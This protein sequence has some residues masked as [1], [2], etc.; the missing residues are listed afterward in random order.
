MEELNS[1][2]TIIK[3]ISEKRWEFRSF[4]EKCGLERGLLMRLQSEYRDLESED[5]RK[6]AN[7]FGWE[8]KEKG[9]SIIDME[10][11]GQEGL[12]IIE[13]SVQEGEMGNLYEEGT[14]EWANLKIEEYLKNKR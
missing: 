5:I 9:Y 2:M 7:M 4:E 1:L 13:F 12:K 10:A 8:M 11:F 14:D 6:I 3:F